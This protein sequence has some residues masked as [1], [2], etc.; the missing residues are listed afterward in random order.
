M[1][2]YIQTDWSRVKTGDNVF[3]IDAAGNNGAGKAYGPYQVVD[4]AKQTVE[5]KAQFTPPWQVNEPIFVK[6]VGQ[7]VA[8]KAP[9]VQPYGQ[10]APVNA[11]PLPQ[12]PTA[13]YVLQAIRDWV[14]VDIASK[15][16]NLDAHT[17]AKL[18]NDAVVKRDIAEQALIDWKRG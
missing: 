15:A 5:D 9:N 8:T 2:G 14:V 13:S 3:L 6:D 1:Q 18:E 4:S 17:R 12:A 11:T 7:A 10:V 16:Q